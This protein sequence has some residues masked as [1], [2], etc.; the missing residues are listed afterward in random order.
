MLVDLAHETPC[1]GHYLGHLHLGE[2]TVDLVLHVLYLPLVYVVLVDSLHA[3][4]HL[5]GVGLFGVVIGLGALS[6]LFLKLVLCLL[7]H[8][9]HVVD[10]SV[11]GSGG[12]VELLLHGPLP[13]SGLLLRHVRHHFVI[14]IDWV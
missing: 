6:D 2:E 3:L 13:F 9:L 5:A 14:S 10:L 1:L 11:H 8:S 7:L 4:H 12:F